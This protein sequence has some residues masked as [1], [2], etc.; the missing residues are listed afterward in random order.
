[1]KPNLFAAILV[2]SS[3]GLA[4]CASLQQPAQPAPQPASA[5]AIS[6]PAQVTTQ[7]QAPA[8]SFLGDIIKTAT[9]TL[10]TEAQKTV[11]SSIQE[12]GSA[13]RN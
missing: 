11:K 3:V 7:Q 4:G 6:A 1:M 2:L 5:D 10:S 12:A 13:A 8:N 9:E